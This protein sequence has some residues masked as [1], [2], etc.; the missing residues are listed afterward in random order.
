MKLKNN[1]KTSF[2]KIIVFLILGIIAWFFKEK[3][4]PETWKREVSESNIKE[5]KIKILE[6]KR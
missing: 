5:S 2:L 3:Y 6:P 4:F 1:K